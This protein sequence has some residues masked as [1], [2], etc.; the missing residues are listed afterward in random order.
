M[1]PWL[2]TCL[3][4]FLAA[5]AGARYTSGPNWVVF[6]WVALGM[7]S[8]SLSLALAWVAWRAWPQLAKTAMALLLAM[9]ATLGRHLLLPHVLQ[10]QGPPQIEIVPLTLAIAT[11]SWGFLALLWGTSALADHVESPKGSPRGRLLLVLAGAAVVLSLYSLAPL[12]I[13]LGLHINLWT[14]LGLVLLVSG[15]YGLDR[16][17]RRLTGDG[18]RAGGQ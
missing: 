15:A 14:M 2:L 12:W 13:L 18:R 8:T 5:L 9:V 1:G 16:I 6:L 11:L 4:A 17:H 7:A 3:L 10:R